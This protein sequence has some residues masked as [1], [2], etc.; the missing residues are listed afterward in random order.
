MGDFAPAP[1]IPGKNKFMELSEDIMTDDLITIAPEAPIEKAHAAFQKHGIRHLPV[2]DGGHVVGVLS[3][4]D[5]RGAMNL[6]LR[7]RD[8]MSTPALTIE[9]W[10]TAA[11]AASRMRQHKVSSLLVVDEGRLRGIL[12]SYDL[13]GV[14]EILGEREKPGLVGAL[15]AKVQDWT[16]TT[17]VNE[18]L[19][20]LS[21]SGI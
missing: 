4:R 18:I 3:E 1:E 10:A 13:L 12:T 17:P 8:F 14:L 9:P 2:M 21:S 15:T 11:E 20:A 5:L 6:E 16:H 19:G 7:V